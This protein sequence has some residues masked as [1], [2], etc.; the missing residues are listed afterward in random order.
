[1]QKSAAEKNA[2]KLSLLQLISLAD[3][4]TI[5]NGLF[6]MA[7]M[8]S[9]M[10]QRFDLAVTFMLLASL[11]DGIDG[12]VARLVKSEC[13]LGEYLDGFSDM[14]SFCIAP[15]VLIFGKF[16]GSDAFA[17]SIGITA[18]N[19]FVTATIGFLLVL[20][21]LRLARFEYSDGGSNRKIFLGL[22]TLAVELWVCATVALDLHWAFVLPPVV[23]MSAA[24]VSSRLKWPKVKG[25]IAYAFA[26]PIVLTILFGTRFYLFAPW[27]LIVAAGAY[28]LLGPPYVY[29]KEKNATAAQTPSFR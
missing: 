10:L 13:R 21:M 3:I 22:P 15:S 1:M 24:M 8:F 17:S 26:I 16:Y 7:S 2:G 23:V 18:G 4:V 20:G 9:V 27:S 6:G 28:I 14:T 12:I 5:L 29:L 11:A 25:W 19:L